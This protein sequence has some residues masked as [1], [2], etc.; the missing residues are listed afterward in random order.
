MADKISVDPDHLEHVAFRFGVEAEILRTIIAESRNR[1]RALEASWE[2]QV[3]ADF[4][5]KY[6]LA[7]ASLRKVPEI[8]DIIKANLKSAA[9]RF[10][11][12]DKT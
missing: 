3:E 6:E 9:S 7:E 2:G 4:M 11:A 8:F 10:R 12:A 5:G 1:L